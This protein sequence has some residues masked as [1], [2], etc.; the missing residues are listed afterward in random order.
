MFVSIFYGSNISNP[1]IWDACGVKIQFDGVPYDH[2]RRFDRGVHDLFPTTMIAQFE[3]GW[4]PCGYNKKHDY[5]V[6]LRLIRVW[7]GLEGL[8]LGARVDRIA[9]NR[10][11]AGNKKIA[12]IFEGGMCGLSGSVKRPHV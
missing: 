2:F 7:L 8:S 5:M 6:H 11:T 4:P 9:R 10:M 12:L 3:M 1:S